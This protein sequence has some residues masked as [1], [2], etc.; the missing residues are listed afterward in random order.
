MRER[1]LTTRAWDLGG[2]WMESER[3]ALRVP[4]GKSM[5]G[6]GGICIYHTIII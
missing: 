5:V 1:D 2:G 4:G 3:L 6:G